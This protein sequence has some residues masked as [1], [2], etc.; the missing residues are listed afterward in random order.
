MLGYHSRSQ[1]RTDQRILVFTLRL[2]WVFP[3]KKYFSNVL[4]FYNLYSMQLLVWTIFK[5]KLKLFSA[6]ENIKNGPQKLLIIGLKQ[7]FTVLLGF[8]NRALIYFHIINT[9]LSPFLGFKD[10]ICSHIS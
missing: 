9:H 1:Q 6:P 5:I 4:D 3:C 7:F 8:P 2:T 10:T